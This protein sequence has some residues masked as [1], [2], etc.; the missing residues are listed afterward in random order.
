MA[1]REDKLSVQCS[2]VQHSTALYTVS[3]LSSSAKGKLSPAPLQPEPS[4]HRHTASYNL[5]SMTFWG[6]SFSLKLA[7]PARPQ[8]LCVECEKVWVWPDCVIS[9]SAELSST[10][11]RMAGVTFGWMMC[12]CINNVDGNAKI[13]ADRKE[14]KYSNTPQNYFAVNETT[15]MISLYQILL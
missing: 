6:L 10:G 2:S 3:W 13:L 7:K 12:R 8:L 5:L 11:P 15:K 14:V 9:P 4:V 1:S